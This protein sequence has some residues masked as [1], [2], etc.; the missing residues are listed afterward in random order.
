MII[1]IIQF[2]S[3]GNDVAARGV[4]P[5]IW[6]TSPDETT[7]ILKSILRLASV[8]FI[9]VR[10]EILCATPLSFEN[11]DSEENEV[12]VSE[13]VQRHSVSQN[14][15]MNVYTGDLL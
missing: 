7:Y 9:D 12:D 8:P 1:F 5:C 10:D 13:M 15:L 11:K 4:C 6:I 2:L 14:R 3:T